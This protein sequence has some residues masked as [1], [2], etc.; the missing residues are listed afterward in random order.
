MREI[1][2][3]VFLSASDISGDPSGL[4]LIVLSVDP[5]EVTHIIQQK[6]QYFFFSIINLFAP[7][8]SQILKQK[9]HNQNM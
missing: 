8:N 9:K 4:L 6:Y 3:L 1:N 7:T 2:P 5:R